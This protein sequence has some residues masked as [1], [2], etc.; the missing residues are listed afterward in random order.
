M[1]LHLELAKVVLILRIQL[2]LQII[3]GERQVIPLS[4]IDPQVLH[5]LS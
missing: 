5:P 1:K 2:G 3:L 4:W